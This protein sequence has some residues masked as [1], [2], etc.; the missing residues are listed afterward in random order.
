MNIRHLPVTVVRT[1]MVCTVIGFFVWMFGMLHGFVTVENTAASLPAIHEEG[2]RFV[3]T[4]SVDGILQEAEER[5]TTSPYWWLN[6]GGMFIIENGIG[7][8]IQ[9]ALPSL[10]RWRLAYAADNPT[11]S[12]G[13]YH[14]QNLFRLISRN[15]WLNPSTRVMFRIAHDNLSASQN[16]N[17]S[18]GIFIISRYVNGDTLYYAGIRVDG[19]AVIKKKYRGVYYTL[20]QV[21]VFSGPYDRDTSA[22]LLPHSEWLEMI[23]E[24]KTQ[25]DNSVTIR[26][27]LKRGDAEPVLLVEAVDASGIWDGTPV[28][29]ARARIGIRSD[30]MDVEFTSIEV[31]EL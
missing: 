5:D 13:G 23:G 11:D 9:G 21:P 4:F 31:H 6:S 26:L 22:N 27:L 16:R 17:E 8:T 3:Y 14:P 30:F 1:L 19:S 24:T 20:A 18:N 29:D 25:T 12:D 15:E 28:I 2:E 7:K 10:H